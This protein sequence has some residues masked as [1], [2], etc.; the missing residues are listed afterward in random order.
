MKQVIKYSLFRYFCPTL[1]VI[2]IVTGFAF[3]QD[4][5]LKELE[6]AADLIIIGRHRAVSIDGLVATVE[7]TP[8]RVLKGGRSI[9]SQTPVVVKLKIGPGHADTITKALNNQIPQKSEEHTS[10]PQSLRH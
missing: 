5:A 2:G 8:I 3:A 7:I 9:T 1:L 6:E 10:E 4:F